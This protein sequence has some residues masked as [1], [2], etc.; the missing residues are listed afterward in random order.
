MV[1]EKDIYISANVLINQHGDLAEEYAINM[2]EV[3]GGGT[4]WRRILKAI[5]VLQNTEIDITN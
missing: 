5:K 2:I 1:S 3:K 4:L